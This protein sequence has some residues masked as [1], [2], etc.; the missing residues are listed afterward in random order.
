[1][2]IPN[3]LNTDLIF[4]HPHSTI[5]SATT[6]LEKCR[7]VVREKWFEKS[8]S[9]NLVREKWLTIKKVV[10]YHKS[11][12]FQVGKSGSANSDFSF[13]FEKSDWPE[14]KSEFAEPLFLNQ[15]S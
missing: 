10:L 2:Y 13:W 11:T 6:F 1:M 12:F 15:I 5:Y 4:R 3:T 14:K 9:K 8:G 7:K